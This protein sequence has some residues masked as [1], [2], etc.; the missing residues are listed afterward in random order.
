MQTMKQRAIA[1]VGVIA[2]I[3]LGTGFTAAADAPAQPAVPEK[4]EV[5]QPRPA[6]VKRVLSLCSGSGRLHHSARRLPHAPCLPPTVCCRLR[7]L[8]TGVCRLLSPAVCRRLRFPDVSAICRRLFTVCRPRAFPAS[9]VLSRIRR[10]RAA[11]ARLSPRMDTSEWRAP[12]DSR[13]SLRF[14]QNGRGAWRRTARLSTDVAGD[15]MIVEPKASGSTNADGPRSLTGLVL[16]HRC[17]LSRADASVPDWQRDD[18]AIPDPAERD[19]FRAL[20]ER[21]ARLLD[22]LD[23]DRWLAMYS[24]E[25]IYWVPGT[26]A[27]GD[28]RREI[29]MSFDDRRRMEDRIYRLRTG[30]AWSQAPKSRTVRMI[31]NVEVFKAAERRPR[32]WCARIS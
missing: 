29:A 5:P 1:I 12:A 21:E 11:V 18:R 24:P 32:A 26:P 13:S 8:S 19:R 30:Y 27:G 20:I 31:T 16:R 23:F 17:V 6:V 25:C 22:Q 28:P 2:L 9:L 3:G 7:H 14:V 4:A 10:G 15:D